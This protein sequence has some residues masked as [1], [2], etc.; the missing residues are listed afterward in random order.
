[1]AEPPRANE[2]GGKRYKC[3]KYNAAY[4]VVVTTGTGHAQEA[5]QNVT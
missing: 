2:L 4:V 5:G 1:M 3:M